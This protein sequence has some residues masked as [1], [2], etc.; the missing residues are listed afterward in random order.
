MMVCAH[1]DWFRDWEA[2]SGSGIGTRFWDMDVAAPY[3]AMCFKMSPLLSLSP[4]EFIC[5]NTIKCPKFF[6]NTNSIKKMNQW[7]VKYIVVVLQTL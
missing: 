3:E 1:T 5:L 6:S 7:Y 2:A 4:F